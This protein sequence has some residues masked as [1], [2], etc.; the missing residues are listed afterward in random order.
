MQIKTLVYSKQKGRKN[1][2]KG[3]F[4][5]VAGSRR[6]SLPQVLMDPKQMASLEVPA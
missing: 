2:L 3:C 6:W 1:T 4:Y 5:E